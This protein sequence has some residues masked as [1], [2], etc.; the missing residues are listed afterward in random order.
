MN[1]LLIYGQ[2][3]YWVCPV[4]TAHMTIA[5]VPP[6]LPS[7]P[8]VFFFLTCSVPPP[9]HH[10]LLDTY[11]SVSLSPFLL[12]LHATASLPPPHPT[13][14]TGVRHLRS[15]ETLQPGT[16]TVAHLEQCGVSSRSSAIPEAPMPCR[17]NWRRCGTLGM[18]KSLGEPLLLLPLPSL[19]PG[20]TA[21]VIPPKG[22]AYMLHMCAFFKCWL[23]P[24]VL[25]LLVSTA[26][27]KLLFRA[28][29]PQT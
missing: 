4:H 15:S 19:L 11:F 1:R 14:R 23:W 27:S 24:S 20:A 18:G 7:H 29:E 10:H 28:L 3:Q 6:L 21:S 2:P 17:V 8:S 12:P 16:S 13:P 22:R 26:S 25:L 5:M 9:G